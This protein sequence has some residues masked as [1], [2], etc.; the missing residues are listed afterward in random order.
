MSRARSFSISLSLSLFVFLSNFA[1]FE[2]ELNTSW[3]N[4]ILTLRMT[5]D[6]LILL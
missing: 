5:E 3:L 4:G 2:K 1:N 6:M